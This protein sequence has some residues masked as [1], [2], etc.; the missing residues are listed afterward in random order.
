VVRE[1]RVPDGVDRGGGADGGEHRGTVQ[2]WDL[3]H[4]VA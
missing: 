2:D 1:E 3:G 4:G